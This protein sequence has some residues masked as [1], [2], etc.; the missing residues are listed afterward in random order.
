MTKTLLLKLVCTLLMAIGAFIIPQTLSAQA[1]ANRFCRADGLRC[2][3][4]DIVPCCGTCGKPGFC[5]GGG[6]GSTEQ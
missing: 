5:V 6:G 2:T 4:M 3:P 1:S